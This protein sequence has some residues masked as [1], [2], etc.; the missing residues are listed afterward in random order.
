M[1][2]LYGVAFLLGT[3][4]GG[5]SSRG[6]GSQRCVFCLGG[7]PPK[8]PEARRSDRALAGRRYWSNVSALPRDGDVVS[9]PSGEGG[10]GEERAEDGR[11]VADS[12]RRPLRC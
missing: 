2:T 1:L 6:L 11:G 10:F 12:V 3:G 8:P 7:Q 4:G 9:F 5:R